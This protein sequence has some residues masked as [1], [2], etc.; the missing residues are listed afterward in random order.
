MVDHEL[1]NGTGGITRYP[2]PQDKMDAPTT[3]NLRVRRQK[4]GEGA[5]FYFTGFLHYRS[6]LDTQPGPVSTSARTYWPYYMRTLRSKVTENSMNQMTE[7]YFYQ[8]KCCLLWLQ[9]QRRSMEAFIPLK[10]KNTLMKH[11]SW[12]PSKFTQVHNLKDTMSLRLRFW[13]EISLP[14]IWGYA[15]LTNQLS[16]IS[17]G[18]SL[19]Y[20][21]G[22][23][24]GGGESS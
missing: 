11:L 13:C 21:G 15:R 9:I 8:P 7:L 17:S 16:V 22:A 3:T 18:K 14:C 6:Q 12:L 10:K 4:E 24:I 20:V 2:R 5:S 19:S 1:V 23:P